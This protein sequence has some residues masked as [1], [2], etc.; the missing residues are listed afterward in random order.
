MSLPEV[1]EKLPKANGGE[2]PLPEATF[3][4]LLTGE[5]PTTEQV[6]L[7]VLLRWKKKK[8]N[9]PAPLIPASNSLSLS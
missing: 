9:D 6:R 7:S 8:K 3:W 4:L 5:V 2:Q 1:Q